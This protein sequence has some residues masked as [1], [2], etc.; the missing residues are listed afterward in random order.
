M[1]DRWQE[2][3]QVMEPIPLTEPFDSPDFCYQVKWDGV[4]ILALVSSGKVLL[5]NRH[6]QE[7][8]RQYS[9]FQQ[10]AELVSAH[11]ALLDGEV[12]ALK[13]GHPS[14]PTIMRRD[15][16][17]NDATIK[18]LQGIISVNYMVFDLLALNGRSLLDK[19]LQYRQ[20]KLLQILTCG[21]NVNAVENFNDGPA[22]YNI[23]SSMNL[24]GIVAK[25]YD[26]HYISGKKHQAWFKIKHHQT[27]TCVIGGY[28]LRGSQ[29]NSLLLGV[30]QESELRYIG[31]ASTGLSSDEKNI[32]T[33]QLSPLQ[34]QESPFINFPD[35]TKSGIHFIF[36]VPGVIVEFL[37]WTEQLN[38]RA[39]VIKG[40][41][42]VP[43][44]NCTLI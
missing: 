30:Y 13:N 15:Q 44:E 32:L 17:R 18:Y 41:K 4:R 3:L 24:E 11:D 19:T 33:E 40:F 28:T 34:T 42:P 29:I 39:P 2:K 9:E 26:S 38:L 27:I 36:P 6:N 23:T 22:L 20:E 14:F 1:M 10:L 8:T 43:L 5:R 12:I 31:K 25:R 16:S 37:E 35:S 7:R 21:G